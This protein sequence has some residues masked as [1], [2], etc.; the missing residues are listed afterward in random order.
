MP[1][2]SDSCNTAPALGQSVDFFN[3]PSNTYHWVEDQHSD[4]E[5]FSDKSRSVNESPPPAYEESKS[6]HQHAKEDGD[7]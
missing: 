5:L 2:F 6:T 4:S 7:G 1:L 3:T